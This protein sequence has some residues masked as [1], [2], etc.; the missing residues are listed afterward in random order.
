MRAKLA[1]I[2]SLGMVLSGTASQVGMAQQTETASTTQKTVTPGVET[3]K[4]TA[5]CGF[6]L[7]DG[8]KVPLTLGRDLSSATELT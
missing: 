4:P 3:V 6:C 8:T 1:L 2:V 7:E 5:A